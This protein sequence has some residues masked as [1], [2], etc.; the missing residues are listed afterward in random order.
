MHSDIWHFLVAAAACT[1]AA[2]TIV[3]AVVARQIAKFTQ[4]QAEMNT[5]LLE[6]AISQNTE[7]EQ[8]QKL[9]LDQARLHALTAKLQVLTYLHQWHDA[10][11]LMRYAVP[12]F[13]EIE[14][15]REE[16]DTLLERLQLGDGTPPA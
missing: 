5:R 10:R 13:Q 4:D 15:T 1:I 9:L 11:G 16:L 14:T 8:R 12:H 2:T 6:I 3:Y 7:F